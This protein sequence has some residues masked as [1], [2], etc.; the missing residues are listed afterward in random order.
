MSRFTK[1]KVFVNRDDLYH[2]MAEERDVSHFRQWETA[3][4]KYP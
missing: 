1:R 2:D 4:L 3:N